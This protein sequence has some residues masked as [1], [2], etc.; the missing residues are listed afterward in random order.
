MFVDKNSMII[1]YWENIY[2][3]ILLNINTYNMQFSDFKV[4]F[5]LKAI[6]LQKT[7]AIFI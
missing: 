4:R 7:T 1:K 5:S 3:Y 2:T 6:Y